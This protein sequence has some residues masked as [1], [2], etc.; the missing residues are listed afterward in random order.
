MPDNIDDPVGA[1]MNAAADEYIQKARL[2]SNL[3]QAVSTNPAQ[4]ANVRTTAQ[5]LGIAP[6][7]VDPQ[8][9]DAD[10]AQQ[11]MRNIDG[12]PVLQ[13][14]YTHEDFAKLAHTDSSVLGDLYDHITGTLSYPFRLGAG[15]LQD[16]FGSN[17][18]TGP[19]ESTVGPISHQDETPWGNLKAHVRNFTIGLDQAR[20]GMRAK[21]AD[22]MDPAEWNGGDPTLEPWANKSL[23]LLRRIPILG[24]GVDLSAPYKGPQTDSPMRNDAL[25]KYVGGDLSRDINTPNFKSETDRRLFQGVDDIA[26]LIPS[27]AVGVA[28][29][30]PEAALATMIGPMYG[31]TYGKYRARGATPEQANLGSTLETGIEYI[32]EKIPMSYMV[33]KFGKVGAG[34]WLA[35][36]LGREFPTEVAQNVA[37]DAV[38]TAIAN[39]DQTWADFRA[40]IGETVA[41]TAVST[42]LMGGALH[43]SHKAITYQGEKIYKAQLAEQQTAQLEKMG[44]IAGAS[45]LLKNSPQTFNQLVKQM[46]DGAPIQNVQVDARKIAAAG[47]S[48]QVEGISLKLGQQFQQALET[49]GEVTIPVADYLTHIANTPLDQAI[50]DHVRLGPEA[51]TRFEAAGVMKNA[52]EEL[53][54]QLQA[55]MERHALGADWRSSHDKVAADIQRQLDE[56]HRASPDANKINAAIAAAGYSTQ[57]AA[58]G[59]TPEAHYAA[60]PLRIGSDVSGGDVLSQENART[61]RAQAQGFDTGTTYYHGTPAGNDIHGFDLGKAGQNTGTKERAVFV[62]DNPDVANAYAKGEQVTMDDAGHRTEE[63]HGS[64]LPLLVKH[65]KQL[66]ATSLV[67]HYDRATFESIIK[68]AHAEGFDSVDFGHIVDVPGASVE[69]G[70]RGRVI[71]VLNPENIRSKHAQFDGD[72]AGLLNQSARAN[73][74]PSSSTIT[75]LKEADTSSFL[76]ELGH[77][78]LE[79]NM[80][81]N[82]A[83]VQKERLGDTLTAGET[84]L[85][86]DQSAIFDW[87]GLKGPI[88]DQ[89][90]QWAALSFEEQRPLH[91]QFARGFEA[92]LFEGKAP[93]IELLGPFQRVRQW[94]L[95]VYR[96]LRELRVDLTPEVRGVFDRMLASEEQIDLANQARNMFP[97]FETAEKAGWSEDEFAAYQNLN[98]AQKADALD[99]LESRS[100]KD[101]KLLDGARGRELKKLQKEAKGLRNEAMIDARRE[102]MSQPVYQAWQFLKGKLKSEDALTPEAKRDKDTVYPEHDSLF[103]AIAKLG[104]INDKSAYNLL[105][106][107]PEDKPKGGIV[108]K[109]V[110]RTKGGLTANAMHEKLAELGYTSPDTETDSFNELVDKFHEELGGAAQYS[111]Q[112]NPPEQRMS[113]DTADLG[114]VTSGRLN[115][116]DL[117]AMYGAS[118]VWSHLESLG[119]V[120]KEGFHPDI[121][122]NEFGFSSGDDMV[123]SIAAAPTPKDAISAATD[124]IMF[125]RHAELATPEAVQEAADRA[126]HNAAR[127]RAVVTE[128]NA[129]A[130]LLGKP[131][132]LMEAAKSAAHFMVGRLQLRDLHPVQFT[133]AAA[134]AGREAMKLHGKGDTEGAASE[135]R[136]E[137]LNTMAAKEAY[138]TQDEVEKSLR[139][140]RRLDSDEKLGKRLGADDAEQIKLIL[141][142]YDL[143]ATPTKYVDQAKS[144]STWVISQLQRGY[145]PP[146]PEEMLS[147][148]DRA[149]F[150][151]EAVQMNSD[152]MPVYPEEDDRLNLL[153]RYVDRAQAQSYKDMTVNQFRGLVDMVKGIEFAARD[154]QRMLT[155]AANATYEETRDVMAASIN[156]VA[157]AHGREAQ[158]RNAATATGKMRE[159]FVTFGV[160]HINVPTWARILDGGNE[161]GPVYRSLILPAAKRS[162]FE[163]EMNAKAT[164]A[165]SQILAPFLKANQP[166]V[167]GIFKGATVEPGVFKIGDKNKPGS[168]GSSFTHEERFA[169]LLNMGNEGNIQRLMDGD[170]W[171][172]TDLR[173]IIAPLTKA[174]GLAAQALWDHMDSYKPLIA[175]KERRVTGK[176]PDWVDPAPITVRL[177]GED[178]RLNGGYYP[179]KYDPMANGRAEQ[180]TNQADAKQMM[181]GAMNAATTRRSFTKS[182]VPEVKGRPLLLSLSVAYN[183]IQEVIHDLAWH[184]WLIDANKLLKSTTIDKAIRENYGAEVKRAFL[185]WRDAIARGADVEHTGGEVAATF[186]RQNISTARLAFNLM[187]AAKQ[188]FGLFQSGVRIGWG[189][190]AKGMAEYIKNPIAAGAFA[191]ANSTFMEHR[192]L[193]RFRELNELRNKVAGQSHLND[194][195]SIYGMWLILKM[196]QMADVPTWHGAYIKALSEQDDHARAVD[197]AD[198]AVK[199]S[200]GSGQIM[201]Q[202]AI[203][204]GGAYAKLFTVLYPFQNMSLNLGVAQSMTNASR[205][206]TTLDMMHLYV[207]SVI[208]M[209]LFAHAITPGDSGDDKD[210]EKL[211]QKLGGEVGSQA[212]GM[213]VGV[214]EFADLARIGQN[215]HD[216]SGPLGTAMVSDT[217]KT[218]QQMS[219]GEWDDAM[220]KALITSVG[221]FTGLPAVQVNRIWTGA[222]AL[223]AGQ[224]K[225]PA[226]LLF[227]YET[228]H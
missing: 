162:D 142:K 126:V 186:M 40:G 84:R 50:L 85:L 207:F 160:A 212:L 193:T 152:G 33:S 215:M 100:L 12:K 151:R 96:S 6:D 109:P 206:K 115:R 104:G 171:S 18:S 52:H 110:I 218:A 176:E 31:Q 64:V 26:N 158:Y 199:E 37:Q 65:G 166:G 209:Y 17:K 222:E 24:M 135:K 10:K 164:K 119:M 7:V 91:E 172:M 72:G 150:E 3:Q 61:A 20:Q 157:S 2:S 202:S 154:R 167:P 11:V 35:G 44:Q 197:L 122:A 46:S 107:K 14:A 146:I 210:P 73:Y 80:R 32:G 101:L 184:E 23:A 203:L 200:Q 86:N 92:F 161:D 43:A 175:E 143:S 89:L 76:H 211:M 82:G 21:M 134:R 213:F 195:R 141:S 148:A 88:A 47:G 169:V 113:G 133:T 153:A 87:L 68:M 71:A 27:V 55:T 208:L 78:F 165:L 220:R 99:E 228:P 189:N 178:V 29:R 58:L 177:A 25:R 5:R 183:G 136:N 77:H 74:T 181:Q 9:Q 156:A 145:E 120:A 49:G 51:M 173:K 130:K 190:L 221:D 124:R 224:T 79:M 219:Q 117:R 106:L 42:L 22:Y 94:M 8:L 19:S 198:R 121:L 63:T 216:Y 1:R 54:T 163:V 182:R 188:P 159:K 60:H 56:I 191:K 227:G 108:G 105:G 194:V 226:A 149:A 192:A 168:L 125:E 217:I 38:D 103:E 36:Y 45:E 112:W 223:D 201:D 57:A 179:A 83:L 15:A 138:G 95:N 53:A 127:G 114:V 30:N 48:Q 116:D 155:L 69:T 147:A 93:S 16:A 98:D 187:S 129:L 123:R 144:Y 28:T 140:L 180:L 118:G 62:T 139:Y 41:Q 81:V 196:Q 174:E 214:R 102:V 67:D 204:R 205:A 128:F 132:I 111:N 13:Q 225:N 59:V 97:F 131:K 170:D 70:P 90:N 34:Q 75:L 4:Y 39:P 66:D 185:S 137:V